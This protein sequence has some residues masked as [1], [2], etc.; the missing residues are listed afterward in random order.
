VGPTILIANKKKI[1][2]LSGDMHFFVLNAAVWARVDAHE[3]CSKQFYT[4][5]QYINSVS[6]RLSILYISTQRS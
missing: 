2:P 5:G 6:V 4:D 3:R 1:L